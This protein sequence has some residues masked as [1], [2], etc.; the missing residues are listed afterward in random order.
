MKLTVKKDDKT[1][2]HQALAL[3]R[4]GAI[5]ELLY[6]VSFYGDAMLNELMESLSEQQ[7]LVRYC[8]GDAG[9]LKCSLF[10]T[11][12]ALAMMD[13]T[14]PVVVN[15]PKVELPLVEGKRVDS[16][17]MA[18]GK[19][20]DASSESS[21]SVQSESVE[22]EEEKK[23]KAEWLCFGAE[24]H[25]R[26][27]GF[28]VWRPLANGFV[29]VPYSGVTLNGFPL[30]TIQVEKEPY[31]GS[32]AVISPKFNKALDG[33]DNSRPYRYDTLQDAD[34]D[35]KR[36]VGNGGEHSVCP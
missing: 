36:I 17:S 9:E 7:E 15:L 11:E 13:L 33:E 4:V 6:Q 19:P 26:Y 32:W 28:P 24:V 3:T 23:H 18:W 27:A 8:V 29:A 31:K 20:T 16:W 2:V 1:F 35:V 25:A 10:V 5:V 14:D 34:D 21:E 22:S 30:P 12:G